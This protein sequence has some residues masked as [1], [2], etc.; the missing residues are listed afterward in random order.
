VPALQN[1]F[2]AER[3]RRGWSMRQLATL[4]KISL[5]K[6]YA[7][8]NGDDNVEFETFENIASAF[9]MSP[10]ELA[11]AIGKGPAP[12]DA[13]LAPIH[14]VL[15][16]VPA[17]KLNTV[18]L[19]LRGLTTDSE[20][21]AKSP[22]VGRAKRQNPRTREIDNSGL[23]VEENGVDAGV[24]ANYGRVLA[25]P[26]VQV[27]GTYQALRHALLAILTPNRDSRPLPAGA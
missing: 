19:M 9:D 27:T 11:T 10:A 13:K 8:A 5:S 14:A 16:T 15:R 22:G 7:I 2:D 26:T 23:S 21:P 3:K 24:M 20:P 18:E 4:S 6:A 25:T 1:F 17:E 12:V